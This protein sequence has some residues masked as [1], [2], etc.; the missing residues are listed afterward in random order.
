[1]K[2]EISKTDW[3]T[4]CND[5][6]TIIEDNSEAVVN[7]LFFETLV[8]AL[9]DIIKYDD[10]E[11][12]SY[13]LY[14]DGEYVDRICNYLDFISMTTPQSKVSKLYKAAIAERCDYSAV[15]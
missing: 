5:V 6:W 7:Q 9:T 13:N 8:S 15:S 4:S 10:K 2:I 11:F 12:L 14:M 1:M 3:Y